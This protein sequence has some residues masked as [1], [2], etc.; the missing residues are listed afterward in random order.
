MAGYY[1]TVEK[2]GML[3]IF[4]VADRSM[5]C[6]PEKDA[7]LSQ[8]FQPSVVSSPEPPNLLRKEPSIFNA[9]ITMLIFLCIALAATLGHHFFYAHLNGRFAG[10]DAIDL[11]PGLLTISDQS[12]VNLVGNIFGTAGAIS[13]S[14]PIGV[15]FTQIFW[16]NLNTRPST[17]KGLDTVL[18]FRDTP[19]NPFAW[20]ALHSHPAP[21]VVVI[22]AFVMKVVSLV[23]P[24]S[25]TVVSTPIQQPC[26]V[27]SV[28]LSTAGLDGVAG[29]GTTYVFATRVLMAGT[30]LPPVTNCTLCSYDISFV[31][32]AV[33]CANI[34]DDLPAIT[35]AN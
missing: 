18:G 19:V 32:P 8:T 4:C 34:T 5:T 30:Y 16:R 21:S 29:S 7:E 22:C 12:V 23:T 20:S 28:D 3:V 14:A 25:L 24:G 17:I 35:K 15:A 10:G 11:A 13:L 1:S 27:S 31:A 2:N 6:L 33:Q 9:R 26:N